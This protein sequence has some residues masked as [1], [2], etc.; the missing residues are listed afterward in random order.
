ML[1][2][3]EGRRGLVRPKPPIP[4]ISGL[5]GRPTVVNNVLTLASVPAILAEGAAAYA[6]LGVGRSRGTQVFQLAGNVARGGV[7]ETAFGITLGEL[8]ETFGGGTASGRS[9]RAVQVGGPLG[10]YL[11]VSQFDLPL[12]YEAFAQANAM[13]GHGGI[14]VFDDTVDLAKMA[15]FAMEF[16]AEESC[17]RCTPC[18][19]GA[20]RGVE[21]IDRIRAGDRTQL[22]VLEDLCEVMT[23]G[24]LCAMGGL[25]PMPVRSILRHFEDAFPDQPST[26]ETSR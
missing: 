15:R 3:L 25:T 18:R 1:E 10:A 11:P 16:C 24:S 4:A 20:V 13:V 5:F 26:K 6:A 22:A 2:S 12:D 9:L 8:V 19:V 21:T 23:E 14:V 17:G 7:F